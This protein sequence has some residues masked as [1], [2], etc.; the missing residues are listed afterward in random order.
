[1]LKLYKRSICSP[2]SDYK[3]PAGAA[4][5]I[6]DQ[7]FKGCNWVLESLHKELTRPDPFGYILSTF[8]PPAITASNSDGQG[9][10]QYC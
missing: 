1:M 5:V 3:S 8:F 4:E 7:L 2:D 10:G 6:E 9:G